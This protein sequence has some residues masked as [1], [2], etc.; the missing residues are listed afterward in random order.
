LTVPTFERLAGFLR[1]FDA[2]TPAQKAV[3]LTHDIFKRP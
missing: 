2:L 3:F 1:D